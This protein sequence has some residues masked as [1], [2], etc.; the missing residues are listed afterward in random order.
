M[1]ATAYHHRLT[2]FANATA[3]VQVIRQ[4][5]QGK[6]AIKVAPR[7]AGGQAI[8]FA[9]RGNQQ[10]AIPKAASAI[11]AKIF[12]PC[13]DSFDMGEISTQPEPSASSAST[14][15]RPMSKLSTHGRNI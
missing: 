1:H 6:H 11:Q 12:L 15:S 5:M 13:V 2:D 3:Q 8:G 7:H 14:S 9:A 4:A 10:R